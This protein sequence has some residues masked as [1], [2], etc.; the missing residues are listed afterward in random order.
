MT[1]HVAASDIDCPCVLCEAM[2]RIQV[3]VVRTVLF[4]YLARPDAGLSMYIAVCVPCHRVQMADC[5]Y[6]LYVM[7]RP[8]P[9]SQLIMHTVILVHVA[10]VKRYCYR[11]AV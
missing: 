10:R 2:S 11:I 9:G 7:Y 8:R 1:F 5:P 4:S 6:M 3:I